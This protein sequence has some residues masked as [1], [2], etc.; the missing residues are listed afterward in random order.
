MILTFEEAI[1]YIYEKKGH[2]LV[3]LK[4]YMTPGKAEYAMQTS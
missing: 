2:Q 1:Q 4:L 3:Y